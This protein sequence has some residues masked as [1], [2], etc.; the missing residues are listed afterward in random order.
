LAIE[1]K[2]ASVFLNDLTEAQK[3]GC[4]LPTTDE[5]VCAMA[6]AITF[7]DQSYGAIAVLSDHYDMEP[8]THGRLLEVLAAQIG[9]IFARREVLSLSSAAA[10][11][12]HDGTAPLYHILGLLANGVDGLTPPKV[13][14]IRACINFIANAIDAYCRP[15]P[16]TPTLF[17]CE[18][19][20]VKIYEKVRSAEMAARIETNGTAEVICDFDHQHLPVRVQG[21][22]LTTIV[23][24]LLKNAFQVLKGV[25]PPPPVVVRAQASEGWL[26]LWV[27]DQGGGIPP[28]KAKDLFKF[29]LLKEIPRRRATDNSGRGLGLPLSYRLA[30]WHQLPNL[31]RGSLSLDF[32]EVQRGSC[33]HLRLPTA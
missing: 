17:V 32:S 33:F 12:R 18:C 5:A 29:A 7:S 23:Y 26:D 8:K 19:D 4:Y 28:E 25:Q 9:E 20:P 24:N 1:R 30:Y 3:R 27:T 14:D 15:G 6:C 2:G 10:G 31:R 16:S 21:A 11:L 13:E 22:V